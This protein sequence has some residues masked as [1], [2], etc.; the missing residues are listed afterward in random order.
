MPLYQAEAMWIAFSGGGWVKGYPCAVKIGAGKINV[1]SGKPWKDE[2][3][4]SEDDYVVVPRQPRLDG[5]CIAKRVVR[6]FV[7]MPLG[8][9]YSVEEQLT[10]KGE[11]GGLQ[12]IVYPMKRER[13]ER[14]LRNR[15]GQCMWLL[16]MVTLHAFSDQS[17]EVPYF[18]RPRP[19]RMG[20][21]AGGRMK[22]P[23]YRDPY[24]IGAWDQAVS[25]NRCFVT[26]ANARQ[27]QDIT[28]QAMPKEPPTAK[29]YAEIGLPW[30]DYYG[31]DQD[32]RA[33]SQEL[34]LRD[35]VS[36]V[37]TQN[38]EP[39]PGPDEEVTP[40]TIVHLGPGQPARA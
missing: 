24:G 4:P 11:H 21:G 29:D 37:A 12:I 16:D 6:Q 2:L 13:Y 25:S 30:F 17:R 7:A 35:S 10:G 22:Q 34:A 23:I 28:G 33:G 8:E 39:P 1:I 3:D 32:T 27:W 9:G 5:F 26:I 15:Y 38:G 40:D 19:I 14:S 18:R 20:L 36:Q 31:D